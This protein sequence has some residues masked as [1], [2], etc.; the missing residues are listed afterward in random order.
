MKRPQICDMYNNCLNRVQDSTA[1][2]STAEDS[3]PDLITG[4]GIEK[5]KK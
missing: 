4:G 1:E 2:D 3:M 5:D